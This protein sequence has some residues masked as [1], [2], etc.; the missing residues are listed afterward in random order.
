MA[1]F[2]G[3]A[4]SGLNS[5]GLLGLLGGNSGGASS[6][7]GLLG[8]LAQG[9]NQNPQLAQQMPQR[10]QEG[11]GQRPAPSYFAPPINASPVPNFAALAQLRQ[12]LGAGAPAFTGLQQLQTGAA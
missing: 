11:G 3:Q 6:L 2:P 10:P 12:R 7:Q 4:S 5:Q 8:L 9:Q 1:D